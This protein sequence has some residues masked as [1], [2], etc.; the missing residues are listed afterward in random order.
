M[1]RIIRN[2]WTWLFL[3][4]AV[5]VVRLAIVQVW[6]DPRTVNQASSQYWTQISISTNRGVI[7]DSRGAALAMSVPATS[8]FIDPQY[9]DP[10]NAHELKEVLKNLLPKGDLEKFSRPMKGRFVWVARKVQP[11]LATRLLSRKLPG[12]YALKERKRVY[13]QGELLAHVLGFCDIDDE[14]LAG[15]EQSWQDILYSP[16]QTKILARDAAGQGIDLLSLQR[17]P[18]AL[19]PGEMTLTID[20]VL[21]MV[22][23]KR[24][25]EATDVY[26]PKWAA[27]VC[28]DPGDGKVLALASWPAFDPNRRETLLDPA[29]RLNNVI[30]RVYE[31]GSTLKPVIMAVAMDQGL[32]RKNETFNCAGRIRIADGVVTDIKAHGRQVLPDLL[33]N[34]CNVG[35]AQIGIRFKPRFAYDNLRQWGFSFSSGIELPAEEEGLVSTPEQWGGVVPANIASGQGI[36]VTPLQLATALSA[37]VNGGRC[38]RPFIVKEAKDGEGKIV[39]RGKEFEKNVVISRNTSDWI[40]NVMS[41]VVIRGTGK[42]ANSGNVAVGGKTGTAQVAEH[43]KYV[44]GRFVASFVGFWPVEHPDHLLLIV[45]GEPSQ[46]G[47]LGGAIAAPTFRAILE[48]FLL[49]AR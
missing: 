4:L 22:V 8:L 11:E 13:P 7:R 49:L 15:L 33:I 5:L 19:G 40:R 25:R 44:K 46:K 23:E 28:L 29:A 34:S 16:P 42:A 10:A 32:V 18:K 31:P 47:H 45:L 26:K 6:P 21:Q 39:Y 36:G 35:M 41:Q 2:V 27:A 48:D 3:A 30:G 37:V 17:A 12:L 20:P 38:L 14:G 24:L 1:F 9:W 43:G